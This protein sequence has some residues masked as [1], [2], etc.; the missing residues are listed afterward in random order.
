MAD[1]LLGCSDHYRHP[2]RGSEGW[3]E[4]AVTE[5]QHSSSWRKWLLETLFQKKIFHVLCAVRSSGILLFCRV[6]TVCVNPVCRSSGKL[7]ELGNA[8]FVEEDPLNVLHEIL[9]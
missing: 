5:E 4:G 2:E 8:H 9:L 3:T 7:R 1:S 6:A